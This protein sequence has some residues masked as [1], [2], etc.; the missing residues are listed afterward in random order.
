MF[1]LTE[2]AIL[3]PPYAG[4]AKV[5]YDTFFPAIVKVYEDLTLQANGFAFID[6]CLV[7]TAVAEKPNVEFVDGT[8]CS[9]QGSGGYCQLVQP[10]LWPI[11][12]PAWRYKAPEVGDILFVLGYRDGLP[13]LSWGTVSR[14][15]KVHG[16]TDS[17]GSLVVTRDRRVVGMVGTEH[18]DGFCCFQL[19]F[20]E[21]K[22]IVVL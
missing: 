6:G 13:E 22:T 14:D 4:E 9:A 16:H 21:P 18:D 20:R 12:V 19:R 7:T 17:T 3:S 5:A 8:R 10:K 2:S 11:A 1:S 15:T